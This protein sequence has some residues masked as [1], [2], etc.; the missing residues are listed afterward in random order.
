MQEEIGEGIRNGK[1]VARPADGNA[2]HAGI[3]WQNEKKWRG[4]GIHPGRDRKNEIESGGKQTNRV[5][6]ENL[7]RRRRKGNQVGM[8]AAWEM[9]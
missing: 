2:A 3:R 7:P 5:A 4:M 6:T 8:D 9:K 1:L